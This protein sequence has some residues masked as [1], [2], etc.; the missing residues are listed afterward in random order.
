MGELM[1]ATAEEF[2]DYAR[3]SFAQRLYPEGWK[4]KGRELAGAYASALRVRGGGRMRVK[5]LGDGLALERLWELW[6]ETGARE[7][8]RAL[9]A[10][11]TGLGEAADR[12]APFDASDAMQEA[13]WPGGCEVHLAIK[14]LRAY[15]E[16]CEREGADP[17]PQE[18]W[19]VF[20]EQAEAAAKARAERGA[21]DEAAGPARAMAR[22]AGRM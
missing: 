6:S 13:H 17:G 18:G 14:P 15:F 4:R 22:G 19:P 10:Y 8:G 5:E 2:G 11:L 12:R 3:R 7:E 1:G 21:L 9:G 16:A 20:L